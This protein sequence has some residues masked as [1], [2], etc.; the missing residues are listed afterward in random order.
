[1]PDGSRLGRERVTDLLVQLL[2]RLTTPAAVLHVLR[3]EFASTGARITDDLTLA[4]AIA[5]GPTALAS[6]RELSPNLVD[7]KHVRGLIEH[8]G[9]Q[10]G[11]GEVEANLFAVACVEAYTNAVRHTRGRPPGAPVELVVRI[12]PDALVVDIVTLGEAFSPPPPPQAET[13]FDDFPEGGFG[14]NIMRQATDG[15]EYLHELGVNTVR[16]IRL[17]RPAG[18]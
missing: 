2:A 11:L 9:Q 13:N 3:R 14:L 6:R 16:L 12:E 4:L 17:R 7:L 1:M 18:A 10:A 15:L 5:T 8:R